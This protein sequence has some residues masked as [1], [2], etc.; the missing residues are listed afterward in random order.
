MKSQCYLEFDQRLLANYESEHALLKY[1][2]YCKLME[3]PFFCRYYKNTY[4][5]QDEEDIARIDVCYF[6]KCMD[7]FSL[8]EMRIAAYPFV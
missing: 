2:M 5:D 3:G 7:I 4:N 8:N 6:N 1:F